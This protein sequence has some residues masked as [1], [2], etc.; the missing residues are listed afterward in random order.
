MTA[1]D[2]TVFEI[3]C[4]SL[5]QERL[6]NGLLNKLQGL[7]ASIFYSSV[8]KLADGS[9]IISNHAELGIYTYG[10]QEWNLIVKNTLS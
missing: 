4:P 3:C 9:W 7:I 10:V 6:Y 2:G 8:S 5:N 1:I